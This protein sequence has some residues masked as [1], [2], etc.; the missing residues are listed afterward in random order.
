MIDTNC[1]GGFTEGRIMFTTAGSLQL[2]AKFASD[3]ARGRDSGESLKQLA[4]ELGADLDAVGVGVSLFSGDVLRCVAG[5]T[6]PLVGLEQ[7]QE[8]QQLGPG[9]VA[10]QS[11][12]VGVVDDLPAHASDWPDYVAEAKRAGI[13]GLAVLPLQASG[14]TLGTIC[15]YFSSPHEWRASELSNA[16]GFADLIACQLENATRRNAQDELIGQLRRALE[17]RI[18]IEQAKGIIAAKRSVGV[19]EAFE[20][21]RKYARDR[22][23]SVQIVASSVVRLG[24][25]P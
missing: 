24:L 15:V 25:I 20:I 21:M 19:E 11:G 13:T 18:V 14:L 7:L 1:L 23:A 22:N 3:L 5:T 12:T 10:A 6:A 8:E 4:L 2:L 16:I 17:T 9:V